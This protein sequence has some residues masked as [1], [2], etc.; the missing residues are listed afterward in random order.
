[1]KESFQ[2]PTALV[3]PDAI[4]GENIRVWAFT[5]IQA[6]AVIGR[7]CNICD[8]CFVEN[9]AMIGNQVT[10]KNNVS[11][12]EGVTLEDDVFCGANVAF[13]NDRY[14]RSTKKDWTLEKTHVKKGATIGSNATLL[15]GITVGESAF[16]GAGSVVTKDVGDFCL[17]AGN[18]A[19][20]KGYVCQCGKKLSEDLQCETCQK[21]FVLI[22]QR[23]Q[24]KV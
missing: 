2:H 1:M 19:E 16:I 24:L 13:I 5:N 23:L 21:Q 15:C 9:G 4:V 6:G 22:D 10:I 11:V 20:F 3:S 8:G 12:F 14:P 7:D 17:V 18:P